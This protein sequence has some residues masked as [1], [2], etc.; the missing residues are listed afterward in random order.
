MDNS[1]FRR[2]MEFRMGAVARAISEPQDLFAV[3][4]ADPLPFIG[5]GMR[6]PSGPAIDIPA[7]PGQ[8]RHRDDE[9]ELERWDGL[10]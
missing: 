8:H 1:T 3:L 6:F 10:S 5:R 9:I 7:M 2:E 4:V